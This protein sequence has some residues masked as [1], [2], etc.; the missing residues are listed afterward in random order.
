MDKTKEM[1]GCRKE[2]RSDAGKMVD[3]KGEGYRKHTI[4]EVGWESEKG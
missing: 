1:V 4:R 3:R 2:G